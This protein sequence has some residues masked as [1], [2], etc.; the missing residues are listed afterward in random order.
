[1]EV[2]TVRVGFMVEQIGIVVNFSLIIRF[3][4]FS[5]IPQARHSLI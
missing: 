5:V 3:S 1:M 4:S 2:V